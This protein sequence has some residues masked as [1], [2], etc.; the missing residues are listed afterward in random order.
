MAHPHLSEILRI[1]E[2]AYAKV[3]C[4]PKF[5]FGLL[6][7]LP[8]LQPQIAISHAGVNEPQEGTL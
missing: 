8:L 5:C 6:Q 7:L 2:C 3:S 1:C 4:T